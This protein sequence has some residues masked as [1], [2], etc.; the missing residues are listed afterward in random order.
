MDKVEKINLSL[1]GCEKSMLNWHQTITIYAM[2]NLK[3]EQELLFD[4][5]AE[6]VIETN[7]I[8]FKQLIN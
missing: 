1:F 3:E 2:L 8:A 5:L 6:D 7:K 4:A